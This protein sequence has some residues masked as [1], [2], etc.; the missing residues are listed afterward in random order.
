MA[1]EFLMAFFNDKELLEC[2]TQFLDCAYKPDE[3]ERAFETALS[4][5]IKY[6]GHNGLRL[7]VVFD[8]HNALSA[9]PHST[10][11]MPFCVVNRLA[12]LA[13]Q[14]SDLTVVVSASANDETCPLLLDGWTR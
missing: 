5:I 10:M 14:N 1:H 11:T 4:S 9:V 13:S 7:F 8:Q 6:V 2:L 12:F 3:A